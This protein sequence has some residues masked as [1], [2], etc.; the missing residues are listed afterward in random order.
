MAAKTVYGLWFVPSGASHSAAKNVV[1]E[2]AAEY[3]TSAFEPH[4]TLWWPIVAA[5]KDACALAEKLAARLAP[6][7]IYPEKLQHGAAY[8]KCVFL[9]MQ[10]TKELMAAFQAAKL[11]L[12]SLT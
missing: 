11:I 9:E 2:L 5:E 3:K 12:P 7:T 1:T 10:E 4:V 8:Y 6:F